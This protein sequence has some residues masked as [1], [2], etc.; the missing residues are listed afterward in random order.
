MIR[1]YLKAVQPFRS[2]L[3]KLQ[4]DWPTLKLFLARV[5]LF[6]YSCFVKIKGSAKLR[7]YS[8]QRDDITHPTQK[9]KIFITQTYKCATRE[10]WRRRK[11]VPLRVR[12]NYVYSPMDNE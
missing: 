6:F 2:G 9:A 1:K 11:L 5:F 12:T 8:R 4:V 10:K 7:Q 3:L